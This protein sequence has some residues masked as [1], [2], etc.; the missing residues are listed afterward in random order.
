LSGGVGE[1]LGHLHAIG[2]GGA[3]NC[4]PRFLCASLR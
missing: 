3:R 4:G 1:Q 2:L